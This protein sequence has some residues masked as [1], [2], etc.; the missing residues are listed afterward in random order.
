MFTCLMIENGYDMAWIEKMVEL[1][2]LVCANCIV[3]LKVWREVMLPRAEMSRH[4][5]D[6][7]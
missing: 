5:C 7:T 6:L 1:I 4:S 2:D 3:W